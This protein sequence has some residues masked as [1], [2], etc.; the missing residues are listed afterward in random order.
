MRDAFHVIWRWFEFT[1]RKIINIGG[2]V[3]QFLIKLTLEQLAILSQT[4]IGGLI[5]FDDDL[6]AFNTIIGVKIDKPVSWKLI[7]IPPQFRLEIPYL[8]INF[9]LLHIAFFYCLSYSFNFWLLWLRLW[10]VFLIW[11]VTLF[12]IWTKVAM[13]LGKDF[14]DSQVSAGPRCLLFKFV[15][16]DHAIIFIH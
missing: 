16:L 14:H 4:R 2:I 6:I 13:I 8:N 7:T 15:T 1:R 5:L 9:H 3:I 12:W 10:I 11:S